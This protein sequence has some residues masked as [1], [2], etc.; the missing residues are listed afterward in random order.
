MKAILV[1]NMPTTCLDCPVCTISDWDGE[2]ECGVSHKSTEEYFDK[3][4]SWCPLRP[5]PKMKEGM[6]LGKRE[7][8]GKEKDLIGWSSYDCGWND[9]LEQITGETE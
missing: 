1:I 4:P 9:C 5:L 8:D 3:I 2:Y 6:A 7:I